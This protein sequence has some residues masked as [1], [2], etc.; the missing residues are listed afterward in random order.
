[1]IG[2]FAPLSKI[3]NHSPVFQ[4]QNQQRNMKK[5]LLLIAGIWFSTMQPN[6]CAQNVAQAVQTLDKLLVEV[7]VGKDKTDP[8]VSS[9]KNA[10]CNVVFS[11]ENT[12]AKGKTASETYEIGLSD[13]SPQQLRPLTVGNARVVE[14]A[15]QNRQEFIKFTKDGVLKGYVAKFNLPAYDNDAAKTLIE[16]L[17]NAISA[18]EGQANVCAAPT[19]FAEAAKQVQTLIGAVTV[20]DKETNQQLQFDKNVSTL[21]TLTITENAKGKSTEQTFVFDLADLADNKVKFQ[22]A[23][24]LLKINL[25]ARNGNLIQKTENGKCASN[26]DDFSLLANSIE[27]AKCLTKSLQTLI[28]TARDEADKRLPAL[29]DANTALQL[30]TAQIST[31]EQCNLRREQSLMPQCL[32]TYKTTANTEG[33]KK[34]DAWEYAVNLADLNARAIDLKTAGNSFAITARLRDNQNLV[35]VVKN[36][37]LQNYDNELTLYVRNTEAAKLLQHALKKAAETCPRSASVGCDKKGAA[38]LDCAV[39]NISTVKQ[40]ATET[41]QKLERLPENA[42]KLRF[43]TETSKGKTTET[44]EYEWNM[45]DIDPRRIELKVSGK[46]VEVQLMTKNNEKIIKVNKGEKTEYVGKIDIGAVDIESGRLLQA[47]FQQ[48]VEGQL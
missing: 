5:S 25:F 22:I 11:I 39:K 34:S 10:P 7:T 2:D 14:V 12:D 15:T 36:G 28:A 46:A 18:C 16:A 38:A 31:F 44:T 29:A 48:A 19:T 47:V 8:S 21:T 1:M 13:L 41:S 24:K 45:R 26:A 33:G 40:G 30:A 37:E 3:T 6:L 42:H 17:K 4:F 23:G 43:S 35:K 32:A 20:D 27:Q 9:S